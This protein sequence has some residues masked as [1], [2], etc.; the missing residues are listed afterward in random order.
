MGVGEIRI[1]KDYDAAIEKELERIVQETLDRATA[2]GDVDTSMRDD[3][4]YEAVVV[5]SYDPSVWCNE[6]GALILPSALFTNVTGPQNLHIREG[7]HGR[8]LSLAAMRLN[9]WRDGASPPPKMT[10][11]ATA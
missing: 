9:L 4:T 3:C 10:P 1:A 11:R 8:A 2:A 7:V 6:R 5:R